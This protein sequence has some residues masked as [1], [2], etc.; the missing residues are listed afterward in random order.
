MRDREH[1]R[2]S[3]V[4]KR[5]EGASQNP[6]RSVAVWVFPAAYFLVAGWSG[7]KKA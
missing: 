2:G 5:I 3:P 1:F 4:S 6:E 7:R